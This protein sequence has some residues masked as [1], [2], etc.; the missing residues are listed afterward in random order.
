M[1]YYRKCS[2]HSQHELELLPRRYKGH[3]KP[4]CNSLLSK[5]SS[6]P[7]PAMEDAAS[8][9]PLL[10]EDATP[11]GTQPLPTSENA[12]L[13]DEEIASLGF[14]IKRIV[15]GAWKPF[16]DTPPKE[17]YVC[18]VV[19]I[20]AQIVLSFIIWSLMASMMIIMNLIYLILAIPVAYIALEDWLRMKKQRKDAQEK[21]R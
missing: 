13:P 3:R 10:V 18:V 8:K 9:E 6:E 11:R 14:Y 2:I 1:H 20:L 12:V 16:K 4:D 5:Q 21:E 7:L 19:F 15:L 17:R